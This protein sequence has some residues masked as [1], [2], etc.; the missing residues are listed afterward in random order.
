KRNSKEDT[1]TLPDELRST[2]DNFDCPYVLSA[3][4]LNRK[5]DSSNIKQLPIDIKAHILK[6]EE[7]K[8]EYNLKNLKTPWPFSNKDIRIHFLDPNEASS[9]W[10][11]LDPVSVNDICSFLLSSD[12]IG[13]DGKPMVPMVKQ[14]AI[15]GADYLVCRIPDW[16]DYSFSMIVHKCFEK[17]IHEND[18]EYIVKDSRFENLAGIILF[19]RYDKFSI[20]NNYYSKKEI[21]ISV[22]PHDL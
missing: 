4:L 11:Y 5:Y 15:K 21:R 7:T 12:R 19:N 20:I 8:K 17:V 6:W 2:L 1:Q 18:D 22:K 3:Q 13:K 9:G 16:S 10:H 14:T